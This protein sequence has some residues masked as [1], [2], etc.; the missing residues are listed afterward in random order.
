ADLG[1]LARLPLSRTSEPAVKEIAEDVGRLDWQV[2]PGVGEHGV[3]RIRQMGK[4]FERVAVSRD[5]VAT[6]GDDA[7]RGIELGRCGLVEQGESLAA[8]GSEVGVVGWIA[9]GKLE[10][11]Q[12]DPL[13]AQLGDAST[14]MA[15]ELVTLPVDR[16][17]NNVRTLDRND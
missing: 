16:Q 11:E 13:L 10:P 1:A 14:A 9:P 7:R 5:A 17:V 2:V 12:K 15:A 4:A 8:Q 3:V 6:P